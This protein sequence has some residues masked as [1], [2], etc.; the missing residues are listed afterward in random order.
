MLAS[1]GGDESIILWNLDVESWIELACQRAGRNLTAA[2]WK[3]YFP[4]GP[5]RATC[6]QWPLEPAAAP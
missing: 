1:A 3:Q 6:S 5:Y 4:D 2:E